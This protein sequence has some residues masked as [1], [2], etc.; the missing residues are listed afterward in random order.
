MSLLKT[1]GKTCDIPKE[2]IFLHR[3]YRKLATVTP[4]LLLKE[5]LLLALPFVLL[6]A[7]FY[8]QLTL[9][10]SQLAYKI[11][12]IAVP[13]EHLGIAEVPSYINP[14]YGLI[15]PDRFPSVGFSLAVMGVSVLATVL[16]W[17]G[18]QLAKPIGSWVVFICVINFI[19]AAYFVIM[20]E[21]FPYTGSMFSGLYLQTMLT[22]WLLIPVVLVLSLLPMPGRLPGKFLLIATAMAYSILFGTV[23]FAFFML[24]LYRYSL[25]FMPA[26]I[27]AVGPLLDFIFV[28]GFYSFYV[29]RVSLKIQGSEKTWYWLY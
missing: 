1:G 6:I 14:L 4:W 24:V 20:P 2:K 9:A 11:L 26:M 13:P 15:I 3:S 5:S 22:V 18:R 27:F 25:L 10:I 17:G 21:R 19:S 12:V 7:F 29:S 23:R 8:P 16:A 28:V